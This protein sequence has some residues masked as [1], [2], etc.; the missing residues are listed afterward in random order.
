MS[1]SDMNKCLELLSQFCEWSGARPHIKKSE[2]TAFDFAKNQPV[3]TEL[4]KLNGQPLTW[5]DPGSP[6]RYLG[7]RSSL[8]GSTMAEVQHIFANTAALVVK[9]KHHPYLY[10]QAVKAVTMV[11][12]AR[13]RYSAPLTRWSDAQL[14]HLHTL[15]V[16]NIKA[17]LGLSPG[18]AGC[19][20][21]LPPELGG[22]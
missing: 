2:I 19:P 3:S 12:E 22:G 17:A 10:H 16:A 20:L 8:R 13:F 1:E 5:V 18:T 21:T 7:F 4:I 9:C 15:W 6:S 11:Q 14:T